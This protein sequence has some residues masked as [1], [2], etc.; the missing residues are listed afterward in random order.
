MSAWNVLS[1][2]ILAVGGLPL[3]LV[4]GVGFVLRLI[5]YLGMPILEYGRAP[6]ATLLYYTALLEHFAEYVA[7]TTLKPPL[8]YAIHSVVLRLVGPEAAYERSAFLLVTFLFDLVASALIYQA[9]RTVGVRRSWAALS[10]G[11]YSLALIPFELW[12]SGTH[13]DH[14]TTLFASFVVYAGVRYIRRPHLVSSGGLAI[15]GALL[16]M[17]FPV[18]AYVMPAAALAASAI[19]WRTSAVSTRVLLGTALLAFTGPVLAAAAITLKNDAYAGVRAPS[20]LAG[21][22][23]MVFAHEATKDDRRALR[24]VMDRA[25]VPAWYLW[26][27]DNAI[28]PADSSGRAISGWEV[29]APAYGICYRG[30][31]PTAAAWPSDFEPLLGHL[32]ETQSRAELT[33]VASDS[34]DAQE[35]RYLYA[36]FS[37]ELS[38]R[39]IGHYGAVS[40]RVAL[41]LLLTE[42]VRYVRT[43]AITQLRYVTYGPYFPRRTLFAETSAGA[44]SSVAVRL[45]AH[46][47]FLMI[48]HAYGLVAAWTYLALPIVVIALIAGRRRDYGR[49]LPALLWLTVPIGVTSAIYSVSAAWEIDR[50]FMQI[51]P[52]LAVATALLAQVLGETS[53]L[54]RSLSR[55]RR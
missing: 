43:A 28:P 34:L 32:K 40:T 16:V 38:A 51:T 26:C 24:V 9:A 17:Q 1:T 2:R 18:A 46:G 20:N 5:A 11:L 35:R 27:F 21:P 4:L 23:L 15:A 30:T 29:L 25:K 12:R 14:L 41:T 44:Q 47:V 42:P 13:Y 39:W 22:S 6:A 33:L 10:A 37:P 55:S 52:Y 19:V 36:G 45:T 54:R 8:T 31:E 3:L 50:Y 48:T 49:H 53:V 7:F